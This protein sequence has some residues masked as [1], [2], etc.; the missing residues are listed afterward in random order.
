VLSIIEECHGGP[1]VVEC[2]EALG[3]WLPKWGV[4]DISKANREF[5][6]SPAISLHTGIHKMF[7]AKRQELRLRSATA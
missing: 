7:A 1:L 4:L 6:W 2:E 5:G 3:H